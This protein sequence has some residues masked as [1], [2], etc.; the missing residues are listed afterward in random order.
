MGLTILHQME[1]DVP[2]EAMVS[3]GLLDLLLSM[4]GNPALINFHEAHPYAVR[5]RYHKKYLDNPL[6]LHDSYTIQFYA[7]L[8]D[9]EYDTWITTKLKYSHG[10]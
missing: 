4:S 5:Y 1:L 6:Q 8:S 7:S 9:E 2:H 10:T 3:D